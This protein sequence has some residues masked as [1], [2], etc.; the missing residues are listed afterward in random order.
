[1]R[2]GYTRSQMSAQLFFAALVA[3]ALAVIY[4]AGTN[5]QKREGYLIYPYI[6]LESPGERGNYYALSEGC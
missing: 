5:R 2:A 6:D 1:M 4:A 3:L